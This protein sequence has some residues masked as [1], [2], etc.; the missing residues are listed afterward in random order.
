MP[1]QP[2]LQQR[3]ESSR[4]FWA[5]WKEGSRFSRI[6][7]QQLAA[8]HQRFGTEVAYFAIDGDAF[9]PRG[10][11]RYD[12]PDRI[13]LITVGMSLCPQPM[14][15]MAVDQPRE[16]R[17]VELAVSLSAGSDDEDVL[18]AAKRLSSLASLPWRQWTWLGHQHTCDW[19]GEG[20]KLPIAGM[21]RD[22]SESG[23]ARALVNQHWELP[24]VDGDPVYLLW[25]IPCSKDELA[26][27][28]NGERQWL[29][30]LI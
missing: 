20:S 23:G 7:S 29:D 27:V 10:L 21:C 26:S 22:S 16:V 17:R 5:D 3:I 12:S 13:V 28:R 8:Y 6:Q 30:L 14:V 9:P 15:E 11:A 18:R 25:V 2:A 24:E 4:Q 1:S 19:F